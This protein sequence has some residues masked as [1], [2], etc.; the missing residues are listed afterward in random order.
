MYWSLTSHAAASSGNSRKSARR[1]GTVTLADRAGGPAQEQ[2]VVLAAR[3][4]P[5]VEAPGMLAGIDALHL[6]ALA[7]E[8]LGA[9]GVVGEDLRLA[10]VEPERPDAVAAVAGRDL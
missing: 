10:S 7:H 9:L 4:Q 5:L 6:R 2:N 3:P 1:G 8:V